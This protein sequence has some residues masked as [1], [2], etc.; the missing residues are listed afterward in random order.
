MQNLIVII[1]NVQS[2]LIILNV[3]LELINFVTP[4]LDVFNV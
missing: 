3:V 4:L 2:A 1:I